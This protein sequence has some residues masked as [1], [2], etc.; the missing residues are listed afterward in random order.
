MKKVIQKINKERTLAFISAIIW[1]VLI[2]VSY[3]RNY[4]TIDN[5]TYSLVLK[6]ARSNF[7]KDALYKK[8]ASIVGDVYIP[9]SI[10]A[11]NDSCSKTLPKNVETKEG[12]KFTL[13]NPAYIIRLIHELEF[14]K[15]RD[16]RKSDK[17][18]SNS[19]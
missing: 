8:W 19:S 13:I 2:L 3:F 16:K 1:F 15:K 9:T 10:C 18:E 11:F 6:E 12:K 4:E 14:D 7:N 17:F 5:D